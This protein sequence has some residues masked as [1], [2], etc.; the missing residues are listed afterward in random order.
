[1]DHSTMMRISKAPSQS[2]SC[3]I[4]RSCH[5]HHHHQYKSWLFLLAFAIPT[6]VDCLS[7]LLLPPCKKNTREELSALSL[8][9]PPHCCRR[10]FLRQPT[11]AATGVAL[12]T[13]F[14]GGEPQQAAAASAAESKPQSLAWANEKF[15]LQA[16]TEER[17][18]IPLPDSMATSTN[19]GGPQPVVQGRWMIKQDS[20]F[21]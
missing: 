10:A 12:V 3:L 2:R 1:M 6:A 5:H 21:Y 14:G 13:I 16:A 7:L 4:I 11:A 19:G 8:S 17:P 15:P 18:R 20:L 9:S